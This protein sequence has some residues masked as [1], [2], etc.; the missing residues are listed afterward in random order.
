MTV[1]SDKFLS[2]IIP[3]YNSE[4]YIEKNLMFLERQT[5]NNFEVIVVD[6]GS[7]DNTCEVSEACLEKF[8]IAHKVIRCEENRGQSVARNIGIKNSRG[9]YL[10]FLDSDDFAENNL[11]QILER[12]LFNEPDIVFFDH[13]RIKEDDSVNVNREQSFEFGKE[14]SGKDVFYAYKDNK[15]RLWTGSLIYNKEFLKRNNLRFLEGAHGAEDLNFIFKALLS[16]E[17]VR[18][19]E[20]SL[21][22]YYQREDSLTNNPDIYKNITVIKSMKDVSKFIEEKKLERNLKD[23]IEKEFIAEHIMYQILGF[24]NSK[25][26]EDTLQVLREKS[27]KKALKKATSRT[28]RYGR[29]MYIYMKLAAYAP[30]LFVKMYLKRTG[31]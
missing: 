2:I 31:K 15:V 3:A 24:L 7:T 11:V 6:D 4:K 9:K 17:K 12:N 8:K 16:S 25:T 18:G 29:N 10:L 27:V 21:V 1:M 14:K 26:K 13:K 30:D 23:I 20:D 5:S 22:F 28:N 19:I